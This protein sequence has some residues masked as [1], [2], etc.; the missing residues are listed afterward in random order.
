MRRNRETNELEMWS[1]TD[2]R[3]PEQNSKMWPMLN[4]FSEQIVWCGRKR[5]TYEWKYILSASFEKMRLVPGIDGEIV[6]IPART[7]RYTKQKFSALIESIYA[8][9]A[10]LGVEWSDPAIKAYEEIAAQERARQAKS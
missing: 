3:T 2:L 5:S 7:S 6:P 4:D 10:E 9:G 1:H 8:V